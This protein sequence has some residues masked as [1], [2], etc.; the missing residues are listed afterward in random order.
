MD[1][2]LALM[3]PQNAQ[4]ALAPAKAAMEAWLQTGT[5]APIPDLIDTED[6]TSAFILRETWVSWFGYALPLPS[7]AT[8]AEH[9]P[10]L[11]LGA[12][13]GILAQL[14]RQ[15]GADV[16]AVDTNPWA[17]SYDV[18][19]MDAQTAFQQFPKRTLMSS[20][21]DLGSSWLN[22]LIPAMAPG[23]KLILIGEGQGGCTGDEALWDHLD[24]LTRLDTPAQVWSWPG[25]H[26]HLT[27]WQK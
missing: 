26:D 1:R 3:D 23:Q 8:L 27:L 15:S 16:I 11:D 18:L 7:F 6:S 20:W 2:I 14:L 22:S 21:P 9:G 13:K 10:V 12:G 17:G 5:A 25:I 24:T 4:A 19:T